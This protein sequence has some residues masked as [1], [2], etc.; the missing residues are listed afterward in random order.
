MSSHPHTPKPW[1]LKIDHIFPT[2]MEKFGPLKNNRFFPSFEGPFEKEIL[3]V[4]IAFKKCAAWKKCTSGRHKKAY[5]KRTSN[6]I[7]G[8][9]NINE[10]IRL[11]LLLWRMACVEFLLQYSFWKKYSTLTLNVEVWWL[12][13]VEGCGF[14]LFG[15]SFFH[16][17]ELH[18]WVFHFPIIF[19]LVSL[20]F[21]NWSVGVG[22]FAFVSYLSH[23]AFFGRS[24]VSDNLN[25]SIRK[26][27]SVL[28]WN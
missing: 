6:A 3:L 20:R 15:I 7:H 5:I 4:M 10:I 17:L 19:P 16:L 21:F 22:G 14:I 12:P 28:P 2:H 23:V 1:M 18:M 8:L 13:R 9:M 24:L 25:S 26:I 27:Y 11:V